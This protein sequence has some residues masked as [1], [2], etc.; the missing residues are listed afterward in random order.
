[1]PTITYPRPPYA[2]PHSYQTLV[3]ITLVLCLILNFTSLAFGIPALV[4]ST[5]V[6]VYIL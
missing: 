2:P 4:F 3:M 1:M 6:S 5:L